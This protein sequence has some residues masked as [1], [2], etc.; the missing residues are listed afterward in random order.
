[1]KRGPYDFRPEPQFTAGEMAKCVAT[2]LVALLLT[3]ALVAIAGQ[4][5]PLVF[6]VVGP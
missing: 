1:M 2:S 6:S 5:L 4:M 3:A